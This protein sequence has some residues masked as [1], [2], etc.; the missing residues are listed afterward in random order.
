MT[1][2]IEEIY[3]LASNR[4]DEVTAALKRGDDVDLGGMDNVVAE[5][6]SE[7]MALAPAEG[8]KFIPKMES[9]IATL[10]VLSADLN[11]AHDEIKS[12]ILALNKKGQAAKAY[13]NSDHLTDKKNRSGDV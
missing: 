6:C 1:Q 12:Q 11:K 10:N 4:I 9:M 5:L 13:I 7:I 8:R 3:Q 2:R